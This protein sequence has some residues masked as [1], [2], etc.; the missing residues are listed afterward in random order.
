MFGIGITTHNRHAVAQETIRRISAALPT[1]CRVVIVDDA[2]DE[3]PPFP[4]N[5]RFAHNAGIARAKNKCLELLDGCEHVFLF[6]DDTYPTA[7]GWWKPYVESSEPHLMYT[8]VDF[9]NGRSLGD[10]VEVHRTASHV[11]YSHARGCMLYFKRRALE[12]VG[13]FDPAFGKWGWEHINLSD[14]IHAA[15]LTTFP[16]MDVAS[17]SI[18]SADEFRAVHTTVPGDERNVCI[19]RNKAIYDERAGQPYYVDYRDTATRDV[20]LTE[21]LVGLHDAQRDREW[22]PDESEVAVLRDSV[23][24]VAPSAEFVLLHNCFDTDVR[25]TVGEGVSPYWQRWISA[26][27]W[28]MANPDVRNVWCV[29]ATDVEMLRNPFASMEPGVVYVGDEPQ[30]LG[31]RWMFNMHPA[32]YLQDYFR[33]Y[34]NRVLLNCGLIGGSRANVME[35]IR[36]MLTHYWRN[37][38]EQRFK[39]EASVGDTEMGVFNYVAGVEMGERISRGPHVNTVFKSF[40]ANGQSWWRHK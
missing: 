24:R 36:R 14:R 34:G 28:L 3:P 19:K 35:L 13:G 40:R 12:A 26:Y 6:D 37:K 33:N 29:D 17:P 20:V 1:P 8:F 25:V 5:Y 16:Y 10:T 18:Y 39:G 15:G 38:H 21:Y 31:I 9:A 27:E 23:A 22:Q 30:H 11:A 7:Q 32:K 2:S 4:V